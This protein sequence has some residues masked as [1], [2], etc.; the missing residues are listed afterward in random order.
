MLVKSQF[1]GSFAVPAG[2]PVQVLASETNH[3]K[4]HFFGGELSKSGARQ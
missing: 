1:D 3:V 2:L 4:G